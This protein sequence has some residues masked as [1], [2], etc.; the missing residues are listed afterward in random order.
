M[1]VFLQFYTDTLKWVSLDFYQP[2]RVCYC[3]EKILKMFEPFY[4]F[5]VES[6]FPV[7]YRHKHSSSIVFEYES[8]LHSNDLHY[9]IS[10]SE[11]KA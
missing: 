2:S 5:V 8:D 1:C 11:N 9:V 10:S 6:E 7:F 4:Q 3:V